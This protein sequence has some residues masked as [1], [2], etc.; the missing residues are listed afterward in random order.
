MR[1]YF[2]IISLLIFIGD[3]V[4]Y[5][6]DGATPIIIIVAVIGV[7]NLIIGLFFNML[8][9]IYNEADNLDL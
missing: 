6:Y 5:N 9:E 4:I 3:I 2:I 8:T 7:L 1:W